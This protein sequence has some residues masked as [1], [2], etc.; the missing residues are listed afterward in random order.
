MPNCTQCGSELPLTGE[1]PRCEPR[2]AQPPPLLNRELTL[3]RRREPPPVSMAAPSLSAPLDLAAESS[4]PRPEVHA[5]PAS[6]WRRLLAFLIDAA[7][8]GG[9]LWVFL[10]AAAAAT[11]L[12]AQPT[13]LI[14][15]D[16]LMIKLHAFQPVFVPGAILGLLLAGTY[17]A[18]FA[19]LRGGRTLGRWAL[20]LRLVDERGLAPSP[21]RAIVRAALAVV[22]FAFFLFGFWLALFDRR[23]QTLHD[24]L[25]STFVVRPL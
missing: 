20:G 12:K 18:V 6:L 24:K 3:D 1:C 2:P 16:A 5:E 19:F 15:L 7:V 13:H 11:G 17:C 8:V 25:T 23:G 4:A 14:G 22:S 21:V 10:L 9:I